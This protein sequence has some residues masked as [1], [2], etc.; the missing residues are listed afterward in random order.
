MNIIS[1]MK[2][3]ICGVCAALAA[4][5]VVSCGDG[6][7]GSS[8]SKRVAPDSRYGIEVEGYELNSSKVRS[9]QTLGNIMTSLGR[10]PLMVDKIN[11]AAKEVFPL[12]GIRAGNR[13]TTFVAKAQ[14]SLSQDR[15]DYIVYQQDMLNYVVFMMRDDSVAV[16]KWEKP[17]VTIRNKKTAVI[18]SS[19]WGAV[20]D[21]KLPYALAS[22]VEEVYQW[23]IDFFGIRKGDYFTVIYDETFVDDSI[24]VGIGKIWGVKFVHNRDTL[25][26]VPFEQDGKRDFWDEKGGSMRKQMLK[27]PLKYSRISSR[28]SNARLHPIYKVYR[29]HHGVDYA[30]P[31]GTPVHSV[32]DGYVTFTGWA[33]GGG[34][35]IKIQHPNNIMTGYLHLSR[36]AKGIAKGVKVTQG[37]LIGYVGSTGDSTGPHLDY[38]VWRNGVAIDPLKIPQRPSLPI[39]D[40]NRESYEMARDS[41]ILELNEAEVLNLAERARRDSIELVRSRNQQ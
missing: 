19:L 40:E 10:T 35:T 9:G 20:V 21:A 26:A 18:N 39:S 12:R 13:Y 2:R 17:S 15:L 7:S 31:T 36:Y 29:P 11:T 4:L 14:D 22:E 34:N 6:G 1:C 41:I 28:F 23:T 16:Y 30:A 33:G 25:Y 27:A 3:Y 5:V 8:S 38:R 24:S 37:Q 32:A